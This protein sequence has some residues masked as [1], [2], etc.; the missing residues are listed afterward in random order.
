MGLENAKK[1]KNWLE[2]FRENIILK[3]YYV[4]KLK[5]I[6]EKNMFFASRALIKQF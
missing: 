5:K 2:N 4:P 1:I 6:P 3:I